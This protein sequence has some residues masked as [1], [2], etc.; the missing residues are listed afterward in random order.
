MPV[1]NK[2]SKIVKEAKIEKIV[3]DVVKNEPLKKI[4]KDAEQA[5]PKVEI[6]K[7]KEEK[8]PSADFMKKMLKIKKAVED[9]QNKRNNQIDQMIKSKET[10]KD[11]MKKKPKKSNL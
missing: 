1:D 4:V 2:V 11:A 3:N 9:D 10:K 6:P 5:T 8:D 7:K